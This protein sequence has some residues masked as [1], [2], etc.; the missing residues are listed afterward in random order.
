MA[1][2][3]LTSFDLFQAGESTPSVGDRILSIG[4]LAKFEA[5]FD[6]DIDISGGLPVDTEI[7]VNQGLFLQIG[8]T[9]ENPTAPFNRYFYFKITGA[10]T[11]T[12]V[13]PMAWVGVQPARN[14]TMNVELR[15]ESGNL[16]VVLTG[17]FLYLEDGESYIPTVSNPRRLLFNAVTNPVRLDNTP[18]SVYNADKLVRLALYV[19]QPPLSLPDWGFALAEKSLTARW[20]NS[21]TYYAPATAV[22]NPVF[23]FQ[24][25]ADDVTNLSTFEDTDFAFEFDTVKSNPD[26]LIWIFRQDSPTLP[27]PFLNALSHDLGE[28]PTD[29]TAVPLPAPYALTDFEGNA[30]LYS[31]S[32]A[33]TN[34]GGDTYRVECK[35][36]ASVLILN[37]IYRLLVVVNYEESANVVHSYSFLSD[38]MRTDAPPALVVPDVEGHL[39]DYDS[40]YDN[41]LQV[42]PL[43]RIRASVRLNLNAYD[44]SRVEFGSFLQNVTGVQCRIFYNDS[45]FEQVVDR[46]FFGKSGSNWNEP[47]RG[48]VAQDIFRNILALSYEF[49]IRNEAQTPNVATTL[50]ND[51]ANVLP[52]SGNQDWTG[53]D[54]FVE[55]TFNLRYQS[56]IA[57]DD[58]IIFTQILKVKP[59]QETNLTTEFLNEAGDPLRYLCENNENFKIRSIDLLP[60]NGA[61]PIFLFDRNPGTQATVKETE[62]YFGGGVFARL[63]QPP[64]TLAVAD[65]YDP[66]HRAVAPLESSQLQTGV[67]YR[68]GAIRKA[69]GL[70]VKIESVC[71]TATSCPFN[72]TLTAV[73]TG[74]TA[75]YAYLWD[76]FLEQT[77]ATA[78]HL[79]PRRRYTVRVTDA[80]GQTVTASA[81]ACD[82]IATPFDPNVAQGFENCLNFIPRY[83]DDENFYQNNEVL[84]Y[85]IAPY[86][87]GFFDFSV[88]V[89]FQIYGFKG[90]GKRQWIVSKIG[91]TGTSFPTDCNTLNGWGIYLAESSGGF[92]KLR[93]DLWLNDTDYARMESLLKIV[94]G[95]W[96]HAVFVRKPSANFALTWDTFINGCRVAT[97]FSDTT[98]GGFDDSNDFT[99]AFPIR[100]GNA[101]TGL[102]SECGGLN[103]SFYGAIDSLRIYNIAL[104]ASD[105]WDSFN[106][107]YGDA[108]A[109]QFANRVLDL[110]FNELGVDSGPE[111]SS[112]NGSQGRII[113]PDFSP[114]LNHGWLH[115]FGTRPKQTGAF[116]RAWV[117]HRH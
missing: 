37:G 29:G 20:F 40:T 39:S 27:V 110:K 62:A 93:F 98:G 15:N 45:G 100:V 68:A 74:G 12:T 57:F 105:V 77:G 43:E 116:R 3:T 78:I 106:Y 88:S 35:I 95:Q 81:E 69:K 33:V 87:F 83:W 102:A 10:T 72:A 79:A 48:E 24:R 49:R 64:F 104:N 11:V 90:P 99:N 31:P 36:K 82:A 114:N 52:V 65:E 111:Y 107:G 21:E 54:I 42:A 46:V 97:A 60:V 17:Y 6:S 51:G 94:P 76:D 28:V 14:G 2:L 84:V 108:I 25:N 32:T 4:N 112:G 89:W 67:Q 70:A 92:V 66:T 103:T 101:H 34:I 86:D 117:G 75:P 41:F 16:R 73:V 19:K 23:E 53:K 71:N 38:E 56:P 96:Y 9:G 80:T 7:L 8:Y 59:I 109:V 58:Q 115:N 1:T 18:F 44:V 26:V 113:A 5:V 22:I 47:T 85:P 13:Y 55:W 63:V 50:P 61:R 91:H 30:T